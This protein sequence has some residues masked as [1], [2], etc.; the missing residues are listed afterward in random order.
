M[1]PGPARSKPRVVYIHGDGVMHW[2]A[3]WAAEVHNALDA[4]GFPTFFETFPDSIDARA[5]HWLPFLR[6]YVRVVESDVL[7]GWSCGAVAAMRVAEKQRVRGLVLVAPYYTDL[8]LEAVRHAG[9]VKEPWDW[10]AIRTNAPNIALFCSDDDP[11]VSQAEFGALAQSLEVAARSIAGAAISRSSTASGRWS[12]TSRA[13]SRSDVRSEASGGA[14]S[15][16]REATADERRS[17]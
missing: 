12:T 1:M 10:T 4:A 8:G 5:E 13:A 16:D 2:S 17:S 9:W 11:Y 6:D 14:S 3:G 15:F 7:L